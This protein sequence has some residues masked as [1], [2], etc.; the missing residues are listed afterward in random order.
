MA[1]HDAGICHNDLHPDKLLVSQAEK[2]TIIDFD[3]ATVVGKSDP[4]AGPE[5]EFAS[6]KR[7]LNGPPA[8]DGVRQD[9]SDSDETGRTNIARAASFKGLLEGPSTRD[10]LGQDSDS[11]S[12][13]DETDISRDANKA[14]VENN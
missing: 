8:G 13:S 11:D 10:V 1:I 4:W 7:L 6:F 14:T 2:V 12:D 5:K 3:Q 9:D